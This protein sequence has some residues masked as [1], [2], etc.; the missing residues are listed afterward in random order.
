M[1][2]SMTVSFASMAVGLAMSQHVEINAPGHNTLFNRQTKPGGGAGS[3]TGTSS[4]NSIIPTDP[5]KCAEILKMIEAAKGGTGG[6]RRDLS[7]SESNMINRRQDGTGGGA[8]EK[9]KALA[10]K[11]KG[12]AGS[13]AGGTSKTKPS[14]RDVID[15]PDNLVRRQSAGGSS[16]TS[17]SGS[18]KPSPAGKPA[19]RATM[20]SDH[21]IIRRETPAS[22]T[23]TKPTASGTAT[24]PTASGTA[25]KPSASG[26]ATK[27]A[28]SGT[29]SKSS[30]DPKVCAAML[31]RL[32]AAKSS[33]A[34]TPKT[35]RAHEIY[36][37]IRRAADNK[38]ASGDPCAQLTAMTKQPKPK[39]AA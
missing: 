13:G 32:D 20:T 9:L 34:D 6:K 4:T 2:F 1:R 26:T 8:C 25:T 7:E 38:G 10:E 18:P 35:R 5:A 16:T 36:A 12:A 28:A 14:R 19:R 29:A 24:T 27:P 33:T 31:Q 21:P 39:G 15:V 3:S 37:L 11:A 23:A 22:G 17:S 30:T